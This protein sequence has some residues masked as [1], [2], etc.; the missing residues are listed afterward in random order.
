MSWYMTVYI[1]VLVATAVSKDFS[2][3]DALFVLVPAGF[4]VVLVQLDVIERNTRR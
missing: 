4:I 3:W 2:T 1:I